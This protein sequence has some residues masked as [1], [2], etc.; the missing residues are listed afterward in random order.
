[1]N[2]RVYACTHAYATMLHAS[3]THTRTHVDTYLPARTRDAR[4]HA[5]ARTHRRQT[6]RQTDEQMHVLW[7]HTH[8]LFVWC[9]LWDVSNYI[10]PELRRTVPWRRIS[11]ACIEAAQITSRAHS[12]HAGVHAACWHVCN[13]HGACVRACVAVFMCKHR[14]T[15]GL[16]DGKVRG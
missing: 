6:N 10:G 7:T 9:L 8:Q 16:V 3:M 4:T 14:W 1:M 13:M 15:G 12:M 11:R 2:I 5:H